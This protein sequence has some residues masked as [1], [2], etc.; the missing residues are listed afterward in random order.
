MFVYDI[1]YGPEAEFTTHGYYTTGGTSVS[2]QHPA[3]DQWGE[4]MCCEY[5]RLYKYTGNKLWYKRML[6]MWYNSTQCICTSKDQLFHGRHRPLGG[7]NEAFYHCRWG[8]R[9]NCN[10][11]GHLNEWLVSWV[12]VFRLNVLDRLTT[13]CGEKDWSIFD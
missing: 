12:N 1:H 5:L 9:K 10:D 11:R 2:V 7:Q 6:M 8:H 13:V 4:L 3:I